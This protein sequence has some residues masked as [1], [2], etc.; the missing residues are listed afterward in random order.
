MPDSVGSLVTSINT[1]L[2]NIKKAFTGKTEAALVAKM[3]SSGRALLDNQKKLEANSKA[4]DAAKSTLDDLKGKFDSLKTSVSSSLVSFGNIT[5]I[6]K[7]GTSPET[8]IKQLTSDTTRTGD[9]AKQL[10]A[11]KGKGLNAA[12]IA[13]IAAAGVTGGGMATAQSLLNA[14]PEQIA[15]INELQGQLQKSADAAG[16]TAANAMYGAGLKAAEGLV[17]G[18]TA[19]QK[20]I[21]ATM[22]AI[23]KSMEAA[24]KKALGIKS[25]STVMEQVGD[26]AFQGVEQGWAKRAAAGATPITGGALRP[27]FAKGAPSPS[28]NPAAP[29]VH[30]TVNVQSNDLL[31]SSAERKRFAVAL[32]KETND[33][34]LTYQRE[35]RR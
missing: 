17:K 11:L 10:E 20:A 15:K 3:T 34:L 28:G 24:I 1:Y 31:T 30:L 19:Q 16:N 27:A 6:G 7:Y 8:L 29:V 26:Y 12:A 33:A 14:T 25:P 9:F 5:K 35:R 18:L 13:D 22:M 2:S 4:L 32:A 21:E 23:A